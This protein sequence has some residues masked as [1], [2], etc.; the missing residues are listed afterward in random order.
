MKSLFNIEFYFLIH[1]LITEISTK[2][3]RQE[4]HSPNLTLEKYSMMV[5]SVFAV[6]IESFQN[7]NT[8]IQFFKRI[9][10]IWHIYTSTTII[11]Y[12]HD[13]SAQLNSE[14]SHLAVSRSWTSESSNES[15]PAFLLTPIVSL[16]RSW[17]P[18][19]S[20]FLFNLFIYF[21]AFSCSSFL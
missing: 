18:V 13:L 14:F 9:I 16:S 3:I 20:L 7:L 15:I 6:S 5:T 2:K 8:K 1:S 11:Y 12:L 19:W 10:K 4:N 21:S 17:Q